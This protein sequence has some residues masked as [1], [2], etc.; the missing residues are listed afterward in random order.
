[1]AAL[2]LNKYGA[3]KGAWA[4]TQHCFFEVALI[5]YQ[6]ELKFLYLVVTGCTSGI[7]REFALQLS[8]A[9]F[10]VLLVS[11]DE[12]ALKQLQT[13]LCRLDFWQVHVYCVRG[14]IGK[15]HLQLAK[16]ALSRSILLIQ[17]HQLMTI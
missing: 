11:R 15:S 3:K 10:K 17:N 16:V 1:M 7:G 6:A 14:L 5:P 9:G 13:Q 12:T 2:Q 8:K 4:G